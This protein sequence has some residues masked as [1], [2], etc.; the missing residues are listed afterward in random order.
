MVE[1]N[2]NNF[3][4]VKWRNLVIDYSDFDNAASFIKIHGWAHHTPKTSNFHDRIVTY[5]YQWGNPTQCYCRIVLKVKVVRKFY[6]SSHPKIIMTVW[7][8]CFFHSNNYVWVILFHVS[9]N[10]KRKCEA[11]MDSFLSFVRFILTRA[12][13]STTE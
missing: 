11:L 5:Q 2:W 13:L 8:R 1:E 7:S 3:I 10:W 6:F 9:V 12:I 4:A